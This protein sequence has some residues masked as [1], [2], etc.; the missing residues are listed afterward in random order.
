MKFRDEAFWQASW[1]LWM[2]KLA[3]ILAVMSDPTLD[4][5]FQGETYD[6]VI[7]FVFSTYTY[8]LNEYVS[9]WGLLKYGILT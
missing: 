4:S 5:S 8:G 3:W 7:L 9:L 1:G 2:M 6:L